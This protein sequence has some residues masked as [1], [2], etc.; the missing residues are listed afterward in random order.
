MPITHSYTLTAY[1]AADG[2]VHLDVIATDGV[3]THTVHGVYWFVVDSFGRIPVGPELAP[4]LQGYAQGVVTPTVFE[5]AKALAASGVTNATTI[6]DLTGHVTSVTTQLATDISIYGGDLIGAFEVDDATGI[7]E[8]MSFDT[9]WG[10]AG[11]TAVNGNL[12][13]FYPPLTFSPN[14]VV[15]TSITFT[16]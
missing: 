2:L 10:G 5:R 16:V 15:G 8:G 12:I 11:V 4:I 13:S 14:F 9:S 3:F 7:T 1:D 6:D